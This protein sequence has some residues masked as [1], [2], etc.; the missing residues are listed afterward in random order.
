M[1][2]TDFTYAGVT[3]NRFVRTSGYMADVVQGD[4]IQIRSTEDP[5][6][7]QNGIQHYIDYYGARLLEIKGS[8]KGSTEVDLYDKIE[9]LYT[10]FDVKRLEESYEDLSGFAPLEW[11]DPGQK[12]ARYYVKP[13]Q[14]TI[15][16]TEGRT[17]LARQ[18]SILLE[19]K[20]PTKYA[21]D[22]VVTTIVV[23]T[24]GIAL[25]SSGFPFGFPVS[26]GA[27]AYSAEATVTNTGSKNVNPRKITLSSPLSNSWSGP[28]VTNVTTGESIQ[29][30]DTL[31]IDTTTFLAIDFEAGTAYLT[32][33]NGTVTDAL[34]FL[35]NGST[36][37]ELIPGS[38]T[39][40]IDGSTLPNGSVASVEVLSPFN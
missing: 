2:F 5:L 37:W 23:D 10:A 38:N 14:R 18:F 8:V 1:V 3:F 7:S 33:P 39:L 4:R 29:F 40:R 13:I 21:S 35:V 17:G 25:P 30:M 31:S 19:A 28:S 6:P 20:D 11:T 26:F 16:I 12:A 34:P 27:V 9:A 36:F 15:I 24:S 32:Y 22:P